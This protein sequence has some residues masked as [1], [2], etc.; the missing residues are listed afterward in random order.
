MARFRII[1]GGRGRRLFKRR[2][3][4]LG[5]LLFA[6]VLA[7]GLLVQ[8]TPAPATTESAPRAAF[9]RTDTIQLRTIDGDTFEV[10]RTGERIRL[11]NIDTPETGDR[12]QCSAE[13]SA[14]AAATRE[15]RRLIGA[16]DSIEVRRTGRTDRYGRTIGFVVIDGR[17]LGAQLIAGG[18]A[19]PWR[20][21]REAWCAADGSLLR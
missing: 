7:V 13:R 18:Y 20:G 3:L 16:G 14:A 8:G 4:Q 9:E 6:A 1:P 17:D 5:A 11:A 10:R 19:R 15:A 2:E 12:A 21:R